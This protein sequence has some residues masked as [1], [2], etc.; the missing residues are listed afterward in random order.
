[1]S[2]KGYSL[3]AGKWSE[4]GPVFYAVEQASGRKFETAFHEAGTNDISEACAA[5]QSTFHGF[6]SHH[7]LRVLLL[8]AIADEL[9]ELGE[10]GDELIERAS[11]ETGLPK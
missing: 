3:V 8:R 1:V 11:A 6:A 4:E 2:I 7:Q 9:G 10:L 5:A